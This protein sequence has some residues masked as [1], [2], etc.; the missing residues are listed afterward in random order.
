MGRLKKLTVGIIVILSLAS[1]FCLGAATVKP[2]V[3]T[4]YQPYPVEVIREVEVV[5]EVVREV[6]VEKSL[7]YE[8]F[9]SLEE[10]RE[11]LAEDNTNAIHLVSGRYPGEPLQIDPDYDCDD[12]AD[13][14]MFN[15][16]NDDR[17]M[18]QDLDGAHVRN[19]TYIGNDIWII[20]PQDDEIWLYKYRR[21]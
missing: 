14:L 2:V 6:E 19:F 13:D 21:D 11:W 16:L 8:E 10:L 15:A 9:S 1:T 7:D 5:R 3:I 18:S 20:E 4:K 17:F 12:Y